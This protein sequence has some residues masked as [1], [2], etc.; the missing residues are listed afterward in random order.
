MSTEIKFVDTTVRD[1]NQSNWALN[2]RTGMML[3]TV[4]DLDEA[5]FDAMEFFVPGVQ[6]KK[7][8]QHLGEDPFQWL[9]LGTKRCTKTPL[10]M[11]G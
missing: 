8:V 6:I 1:G 4:P 2:M 10:R 11:H 5:G 9:K 7:M 3:A